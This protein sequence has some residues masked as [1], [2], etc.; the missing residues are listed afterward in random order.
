MASSE[1]NPLGSLNIMAVA[2]FALAF[3]CTAAGL[4][5]SII[6]LGQIKRSD[7]AQTG[8]GLA[9]AGLGISFLKITAW[10]VLG[11]LAMIYGKDISG[12]METWH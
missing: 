6:A 8:R 7:G 9:L 12:V 2:G 1:K 11:V 4:V 5:V 3:M 10:V